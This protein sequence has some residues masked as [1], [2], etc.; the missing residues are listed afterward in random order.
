MP[1]R[2]QNSVAHVQ[3][4]PET[5]FCDIHNMN[6]VG[7]RVR[8]E[9]TARGMTLDALAKAIGKRES[10]ISELERGGIKKGSQLHRLAEVLGVTVTWLETGKGP[11]HPKA[12][13]AV[14]TERGSAPVGQA[15]AAYLAASP[16][17]RA[18]ID[19]LLLPAVEREAAC[20]DFPHLTTGISLLEGEATKAF[21]ARKRA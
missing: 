6:T 15:W 10:Y 8:D 14:P 5:G 4:H 17:T 13:L 1:D 21:R 18:A 3:Q 9:R 20:R 16:A 12:L 19:L 7:E 11:R 2:L